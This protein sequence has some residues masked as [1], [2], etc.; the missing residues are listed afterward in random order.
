MNPNGTS[1]ETV[2]HCSVPASSELQDGDI[3]KRRQLP[4]NLSNS[5][6]DDSTSDIYTPAETETV[7]SG[8]D[9]G[10]T[11]RKHVTGHMI[12]HPTY[13]DSDDSE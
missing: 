1:G 8:H 10:I 4:I 7:A 5:T 3:S 12:M 2:I 9:D 13:S 6:Y 11:D